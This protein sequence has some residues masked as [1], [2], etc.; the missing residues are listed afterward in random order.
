MATKSKAKESPRTIDTA[1]DMMLADVKE[2]YGESN[3]RMPVTERQKKLFY[4][5][6]LSALLFLKGVRIAERDRARRAIL[7]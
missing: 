3:L 1:I 4:S 7:R 6:Q 5:G 2:A